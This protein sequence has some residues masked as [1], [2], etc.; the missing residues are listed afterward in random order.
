V[1]LFSPCRWLLSHRNELNLLLPRDLGTR[2]TS[3][4][5]QA[6]QMGE[7]EARELW[8]IYGFVGCFGIDCRGAM[9]SL[10]DEQFLDLVRRARDEYVTR[11]KKSITTAA[12]IVLINHFIDDVR[13]TAA[14]EPVHFTTR[15][16]LEAQ[17]YA[18]AGYSDLGERKTNTWNSIGSDLGR[19][20]SEFCFDEAAF[21]GEWRITFQGPTR[22]FGVPARPGGLA[23]RAVANVR[24]SS[25]SAVRDEMRIAAAADLIGVCLCCG[26][27]YEYSL[28]HRLCTLPSCD[29][30]LPR[31]DDA[32]A[33]LYVSILPQR[34][35]DYTARLS[36]RE[37]DSLFR[38]VDDQVRVRSSNDDE[39]PE[40]SANCL[41][42]EAVLPYAHDHLR[43]AGLA[44]GA[45]IVYRSPR[46]ANHS[47][48]REVF[49]LDL[50][51]YGWSNTLKD[52][53]SWA[54]INLA[55]GAGISHLALYTAGNAGVS[56][57]KMAY[58]LNGITN[59]SLQ[60]YTFVDGDI[61]VSLRT[62]LQGWGARV[63]R[64]P[65]TSDAPRLLDPR[66]VWQ[67]IAA[68][69]GIEVPERK[70]RWHVT[71][72]WDGVGIV[73]YRLLF[74]EV[75]RR[76][77]PNFVVLPIGTGSLFVGAHLGLR[78]ALTLSYPVQLI[79]V[80]PSGKSI[81]TASAAHSGDDSLRSIETHALAP[82]L[83]GDYTPLKPCVL[84][85]IQKHGARVVAVN[86]EMQVNIGRYVEDTAGHVTASEPSAML[87]FAALRGVNGRQGVHEIARQLE[88]PSLPQ[89]REY[90]SRSRVLVVNTG[91]GM[92][93]HGEAKFMASNG[94]DD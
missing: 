43:S 79:G 54:T 29:A 25:N 19:A 87:A 73:M 88:A 86:R 58:S 34:R 13:Q 2:S 72:G 37:R 82:K 51:T 60:I 21:G 93:G 9:G 8:M 85:I 74:R 35:A 53:K 68:E 75:V 66:A 52:P 12:A 18:L 1:K 59:S 40:E 71:D 11:H 20:L 33:D 42:L 94:R 76:L 3:L 47:K 62:Y 14:R 36:S 5:T 91:L 22:S 67:I 24:I 46:L 27:E 89:N 6:H 7:R 32:D 57:A 31:S 17:V 10:N 61:D 49:V 4:G 15:F 26:A 38:V 56:L 80:V 81:L 41:P 28:D 50:S 92:I 16:Q 63:V 83:V 77:R 70:D 30:S 65:A 23:V 90:S 48:F 84:H 55:I 64:L 45:P 69:T 39:D 78:D 44:L